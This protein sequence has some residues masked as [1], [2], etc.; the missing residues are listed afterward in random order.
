MRRSIA[1][2]GLRVSAA[3]TSA[4]G[5]WRGRGADRCES[6]PPRLKEIPQQHRRL[7]FADGRIHLRPSD[8]RSARKESDAGLHR[9]AFRVSCAVIEPP[10]PR[11]RDRSPRTSCRVPASHR[12]RS[13]S[14]VRCRER[15]RR[16]GAPESRHGRWVAIDQGTVSCRCNDFISPHDHAADRHF[17]CFARLFGG[18]KR[19]V[20]ERWC[21]HASYPAANPV[22]RRSHSVG[23][24]ARSEII[25]APR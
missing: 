17:P 3:A 7:V 25:H 12:D 10:N 8:G 15:V 18:L 24:C 4:G 13:P 9:A 23:P 21:G 16:L 6:L 5:R 22:K 2:N 20:H 14:V 19:H 1:S 11:E